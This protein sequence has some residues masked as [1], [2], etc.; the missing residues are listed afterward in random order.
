M[1]N[2]SV[3]DDLLRD[4]RYAVRSIQQNSR[5]A[6]LAIVIMAL[7]IG[8]NTAVFSVINAVLLRP[9][10][11]K[12]SDRIVTLC[13]DWGGGRR[14]FAT[15]CSQISRP[16]FQDWHDQNSSFDAMAYYQANATTAVM[17]GS[18]AEYARGTAV[19]AEFFRVF[20]AEPAIGRLFN[21][22]EM[23]AGNSGLGAAAI[24][25]D[26]YWHDRFGG[27]G[28]VLGKT[29]RV[30]GVTM[31]V[32]GVMPP[33]FEFPYT[34]IWVP[35]ARSDTRGN[36]NYLAVGRLKF[37]VS[38]AQAQAEMS[39]IAGQL[40]QQYPD[41]RGRTLLLRK[42]QDQ[43]VR[44][45]RLT[46]YLL[47][48]VV[49]MVLLIACAN[50]ATLLLS[51]AVSRTQEVAV[52]AALGAS[53]PRII[54]QLITESILLALIAGTFGLLLA[55]WGADALVALAPG[56]V[57]RLSQATIDWRAVAFTLVISVGTSLVFG[58]IPALQASKVNLIDALKLGGTRSLMSRG[59]VRTRGILVICEIA[60]AVVLLTGAGLLLK[61]LLALHNQDLGFQPENVLVMRATGVRS[62]Q[63]NNAFFRELLSRIS[64]QPG[65]LAAG[66]M[67]APPG[68]TQRDG[69]YS[70]DVPWQPDTTNAQRSAVKNVVTPGTFAAL[71]IPLKSGR[72]FREGD[73]R[74]TPFVAVVNEALVR[75]AFS[76]ADPAGRTIFCNS[77][78]QPMTIIGVVGDVGQHGAFGRQVLGTNAFGA[79]A[80]CYM[81]YRQIAYN[82]NTLS[83][84]VRTTQDPETFS[85]ALRRMANELSPEVPV[86]FTTMQAIISRNVS[87]PRFRALLFGIFAALAV[88]LA[89]AGVYAVLAYA[90]QQRAPEIG[91]RIALG[92]SRRSVLRLVLGQGVMLT[93]IGLCMGLVAALGITRI[94][95]S[96]LFRVQ[97]FDT[98]TYMG[99]T[100]VLAAMTLL[101]GYFPA[102][103]AMSVDPMKVLKAD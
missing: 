48:G 43:V 41:D 77:N 20:G 13:N 84:V 53:Q 75:Q 27:R 25:S 4:V 60:L 55:A 26:A 57:P 28:D 80:E 66:A 42:L 44:E 12:N 38:L 67:M 49:A 50:T 39:A 23:Q 31:P 34:D 93:T 8:A 19:S 3:I 58:L 14:T 73:V 36:Y 56:N 90:V 29:I 86:S 10:P 6:V 11:Y 87:E 54:R 101:A 74:E 33:G 51:K 97:P 16:D 35:L 96:I 79:V 18:T 9:L 98:P 61:T 94:L 65:V 70:I 15:G 7:G 102:R 21:T 32:V 68:E 89:M 52:R 17:P 100:I 46:L 62:I 99:V 91:L 69:A 82:G 22:D 64:A 2:L 71:G 45:V 5:F 37:G 88:C 72:D 103:R 85:G 95:T 24:I 40:G 47:W 78:T 59:M 63:E 1:P 81:T 92:A 30:S 76:G 83:I